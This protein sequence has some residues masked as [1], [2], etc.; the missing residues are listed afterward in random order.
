M[1]DGPGLRNAIYVAGCAHHCPGCHNPESWDFNGGTEMTIDEILDEV[2][3]DK[4]DITITGG[5]PFYQQ[6]ELYKLLIR[7]K[8][9]RKNI[10]VYTGFDYDDIKTSPC[11]RF[12]DTLVDRPYVESLRET[13]TFRGSS[14]QRF[15]HPNEQNDEKNSSIH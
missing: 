9:L 11:L 7:L 14:N 13:S 10:W 15:I 1:A 4:V 12:I 3:E 6:E 5:D 2:V 8:S